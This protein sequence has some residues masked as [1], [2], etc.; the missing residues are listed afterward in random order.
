M[1][2]DVNA[3]GALSFSVGDPVWVGQESDEGD[4]YNAAF[5]AKGVPVFDIRQSFGMTDMLVCDCAKGFARPR[6]LRTNTWP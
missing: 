1:R 5:L 3:I 6:L 2:P 4:V